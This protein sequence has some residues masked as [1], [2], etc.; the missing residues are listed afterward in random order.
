MAMK[1]GQ[2]DTVRS[3]RIV[4]L[5]QDSKNII[6]GQVVGTTAHTVRIKETDGTVVKCDKDNIHV[7]RAS[8]NDNIDAMKRTLREKVE[9]VTTARRSLISFVGSYGEKGK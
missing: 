3:R 6:D 2:W 9:T 4:V 5:C 8:S 7:F 1:K